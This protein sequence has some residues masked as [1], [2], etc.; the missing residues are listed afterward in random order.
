MK[1]KLIPAANELIS[2]MRAFFQVG[3][4]KLNYLNEES[5][6]EELFSSY[7]MERFDKT[8]ATR[9]KLCTNPAKE[10]LLKRLA[11]NEITLR[12]VVSRIG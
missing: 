11:N 5:M 4:T 3:D 7:Q 9:H 8:Q 2:N 10:H 1:L 6:R 12:E